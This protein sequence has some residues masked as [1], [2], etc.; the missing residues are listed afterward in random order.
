VLTLGRESQSPTAVAAATPTAVAAATHPNDA[1]G[2]YK[3]KEIGPGM[4][5]FFFFYLGFVY[6]ILI[7]FFRN[8]KYQI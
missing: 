8:M 4:I 7:L 2:M 6:F 1:R 3:K 5:L